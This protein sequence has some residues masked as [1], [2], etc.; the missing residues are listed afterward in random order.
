MRR[1]LLCSG[2]H[3]RQQ[4]LD[5]LKQIV[6]ERRPEG[7]FFVGGILDPER[8]CAARVTPWSLTNDDSLFIL[9][10][11]RTLGGLGVFSAVIPGWTGEPME[12]FL[13]LGMQAELESPHVHVAHATLLQEGEVAVCGIGGLIAEHPVLG[14]DSCS[15]TL[16]KYFLRSLGTAKQPRKV[17]LLSTPPPGRLGGL[18]GC[19][20][21]QELIDTYHPSLCVVGG[22]NERHGTERLG[23]TLVVNPGSLSDG[24]AAWLDW[25]QPIHKQVEFLDLHSMNAGCASILESAAVAEQAAV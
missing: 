12:E 6:K 4:S 5:W 10:F 23:R 1:C 3:G 16:T 11:F 9:K 8:R 19:P 18:E 25:H 15:R 22:S 24:H 14:A 13:Q 17:L 20:L 21:V 2:V 7:I